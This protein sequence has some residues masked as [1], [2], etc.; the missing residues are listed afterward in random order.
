MISN[1]L[2]TDKS[3]VIELAVTDSYGNTAI[4]SDYISQAFFTMDF[5]AGG[6]GIGIGTVAS[7]DESMHPNGLLTCAMD[8]VFTSMAGEIKM[9]AGNAIPKGWLSCDGSEVSKATYPK[10]Y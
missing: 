6:K 8:A 5:L 10:L 7:C 2:L 4:A 3:Y 1:D 9:W